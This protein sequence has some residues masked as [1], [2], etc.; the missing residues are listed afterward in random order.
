M[1]MFNF[2]FFMFSYISLLDTSIK[3]VYSC[4]FVCVC[5]HARA[6]VCVCVCILRFHSCHKILQVRVEWVQDG[7][8]IDLL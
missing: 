7:R 6:R 8:L 2:M 1:A 3:L 5:V 4:A